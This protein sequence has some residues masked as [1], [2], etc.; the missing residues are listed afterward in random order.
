MPN[1]YS[2]LG[3]N[4][5]NE[6]TK[7]MKRIFLTLLLLVPQD[8]L[9]VSVNLV[10]VGVRVTDTKGRNVRG[11]KAENFSVFDDGIP[12]KLEVFSSDEQSV[13]LGILL[14]HS[15]SMGF[16][17]KLDRA[18]EAAAALVRSTQAGSEFFFFAFDNV[19][20]ETAY[21]TSDRQ[22]IESA[23]QRTSLGFGTSLYDA[24][25]RGV[26]LYSRAQLPRQALV[27][28]SDGADQHSSHHLEEALQA[29]RESETQVFTIGYFTEEEEAQFRGNAKPRLADGRAIDN[30]RKVL[31]ELAR[32]SGAESFFPKSDAELAKAV[33]KIEDDLRTQYT[34][35]FYPTSVLENHYHELRVQVR[36]GRY[37][38]RARP[39]YGT[40]AR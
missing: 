27:I 4:Y 37:E 40:A 25:L 39:G 32:D 28:I 24:I 12:Q 16:N 3:S 15:S 38:V 13:A 17:A 23:I 14:D 5:L 1:S 21:V 20:P 29:V 34:L 18:K 36:G 31:E 19:V 22:Q 6:E 8:T 11:L 30:P 9:K 35:A 33:E 26:G 10:T 7:R 2:M